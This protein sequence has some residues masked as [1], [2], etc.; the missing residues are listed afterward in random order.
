MRCNAP[1][2]LGGALQGNGAAE[3]AASVIEAQIGMLQ[4]FWPRDT[5]SILTSQSKLATC[6]HDLKRF[7]EA[8]CLK[9]AVYD[10]QLSLTGPTTAPKSNFSAKR[11]VRLRAQRS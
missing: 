4:R 8:L 10:T 6:Y 7:D 5:T 9:R 2:R 3:L 1:L 11:R